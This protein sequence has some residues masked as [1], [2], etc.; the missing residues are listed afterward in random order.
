MLS[1]L[2]SR[3]THR[4]LALALVPL[5]GCAAISTD[6]FDE[7]VDGAVA[8]ASVD[9][10]E[11]GAQPP[12]DTSVPPPFETGF[13]DTGVTF[14]DT[15]VAP[16]TRPDT[17]PDSAPPPVDAP[18]AG[19][20]QCSNM[21]TGGTTCTGGQH[22]CITT[23]ASGTRNYGCMT[24][25]FPGMCTGVDLA[26][27]NTADC[28]GSPGTVCCGTLTNMP[29]AMSTLVSASSCQAANTCTQTNNRIILCN[30]SQPNVC[31][32]GR[33]CKQSTGTLP[34]YYLCLQ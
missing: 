12:E 3:F 25:S 15:A 17:R 32:M 9:V 24:V 6:A 31:P 30:P 26:C 21:P 28:A 34:G 20:V 33:T 8:D 13:R 22:C 19:D 11:D 7:A 4:W 14:P 29:G 10:S 5:L 2:S 16:D 23:S 27:D 1:S 18:A